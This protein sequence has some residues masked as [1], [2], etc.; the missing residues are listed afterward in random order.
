MKEHNLVVTEGEGS[1][2]A[3]WWE[4]HG[5]VQRADVV[6]AWEAAGL[7]PAA[8]PPAITPAQA[9]VRA[10]E[11]MCNAGDRVRPIANRPAA[12]GDRRL[13]SG[14]LVVEER[15]GPDGRPIYARGVEVRLL[16]N[17]TPGETE[18][19]VEIDAPSDAAGQRAAELYAVASEELR[20][21]DLGGWLVR[22][23]HSCAAVRLRPTGGL[24]YIPPANVARWRA[25]AAAIEPFSAAM[26]LHTMP[27]VA[28]R[29][30]VRAILAGVQREAD[31]ALAAFD[32]AWKEG[33]GTRSLNARARDVAALER[34]LQT[35]AG[36]LGTQ[37]D[38]LRE[39]VTAASVRVGA[40]QAELEAARGA[41]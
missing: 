3:T 40:A 27:V 32:E 31:D 33:A 38:E 26:G 25:Y 8:G 19:D 23:A 20:A 37:L 6:K 11:Q 35:Y 28:A 13:L 30:A 34:L 41:A 1:G 9:W 2:L 36:L 10:L 21:S 17:E 5:T 39:R 22:L 24:Y 15:T 4:L 12:G 14:W 7:D 18:P 16:K 29:D